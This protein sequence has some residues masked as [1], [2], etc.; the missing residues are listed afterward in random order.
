MLSGIAADR[1]SESSQVQTHVQKVVSSSVSLSVQRDTYKSLQCMCLCKIEVYKRTSDTLA[2]ILA[3]L[4]SFQL[5]KNISKDVFTLTFFF[6][7]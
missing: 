6:S 5:F 3:L 4:G 7:W 2:L 1:N